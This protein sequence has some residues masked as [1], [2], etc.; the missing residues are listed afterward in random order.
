[1]LKPFSKLAE[2][3]PEEQLFLLENY[4]A[5]LDHSAEQMKLL[6]QK[7]FYPYSVKLNYHLKDCGA[8]IY[9]EGK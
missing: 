4:F 9:K 6:K 7:G 5:E 1:M 3:L 2:N 8:T